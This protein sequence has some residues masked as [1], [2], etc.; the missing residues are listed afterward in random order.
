MTVAANKYPTKSEITRVVQAARALKIA[1]DG[2]EVRRDG[3]IRVL[4]RQPAG[5]SDNAFD[6][7]KSGRQKE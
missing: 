2:I 6:R 5:A 7:W 1:V 3:T 4:P